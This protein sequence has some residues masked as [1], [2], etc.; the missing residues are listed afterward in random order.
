MKRILTFCPH[1]YN[2]FK[3]EYPQFGADFEVIHHT[4]F[5]SGLIRG[6][7][8]KPRQALDDGPLTYH[9]SCYLGR[10]NGIYETPREIVRSL[11]GVSY[12]DMELSRWRGF[13]CG[14]GGGH[15]LMDIP[16]GERV[17]NMRVDQVLEAGAA[18]VAL[19]C[20][21]C[22]VM[23]DDAI[24]SREAEGRLSAFDV[25]ELLEKAL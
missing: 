6:G 8:L 5:L 19:A 3:N 4:E 21:F 10:H 13:C 9:D 20:P 16:I 1:C 11:P 25:A 24:K 7:R 23:F 14:G 17:S 12:R 15:A 2:T 18:R 22:M